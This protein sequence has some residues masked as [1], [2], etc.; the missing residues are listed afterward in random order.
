MISF[1]GINCD[2]CPIYIATLKGDNRLKAALARDLTV[3]G[4]IFR[5]E[6]IN[7]TGC[8]QPAN[9]NRKMKGN[10]EIRRCAL[11][12]EIA[13]CGECAEYPCSILDKYLEKNSK[14]RQVLDDIHIRLK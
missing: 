6:D 4:C 8:L 3:E 1:C 5:I 9:C 13:N 14:Q 10:C 7:C 2:E 12:H 11:R